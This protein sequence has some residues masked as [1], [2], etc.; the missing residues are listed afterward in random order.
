VNE[1]LGAHARALTAIRYLTLGTV[2]ADGRPWVTPVYFAAT[3]DLRRFYWMSTETSQHSR[4]VEARPQVS[5]AV[6]DSTVPPYHGR[7][8]YGSGRA[9]VVPGEELGHGLSIYPGPE[10]RGGSAVTEDDVTGSSPWR[11]YR[12]TVHDLWV[13]C[14]R[15]PRQP[16]PRH[17][18]NEDHRVRVR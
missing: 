15:E 17:R 18:R 12:A 6:F 3:E 8:L 13:L 4:N 11:L 2:D 16:C 9:E 1:E 10:E 5:L 14:P 7:C